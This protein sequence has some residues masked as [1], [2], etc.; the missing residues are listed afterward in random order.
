MS[1]EPLNR[2][3]DLQEEVQDI[4]N[5]NLEDS[6][7]KIRNANNSS[8]NNTDYPVRGLDTNP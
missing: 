2:D 3:E 4:M 7:K 5:S 8:T 6:R 1:E